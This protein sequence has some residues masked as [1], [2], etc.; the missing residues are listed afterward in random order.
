MFGFSA[1]KCIQ[2]KY[3][4]PQCN[5]NLNVVSVCI[6]FL[7]HGTGGHPNLPLF[8]AMCS[9]ICTFFVNKFRTRNAFS[10][11]TVYDLSVNRAWCAELEMHYLLKQNKKISQLSTRQLI[12]TCCDYFFFVSTDIWRVKL[13]RRVSLD[14]VRLYFF[15]NTQENSELTCIANSVFGIHLPLIF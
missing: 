13:R 15:L 6:M 2:P 10:A 8:A 14:F 9:V 3:Q 12:S 1:S 11:P 5:Y 7:G 4:K